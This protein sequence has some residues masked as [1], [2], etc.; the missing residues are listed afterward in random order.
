MKHYGG[1]TLNID[2]KKMDQAWVNRDKDPRAM[3]ELIGYFQE[4]AE[5]FARKFGINYYYRDDYISESLDQAQRALTNFN[6]NKSTTYSYFYK[7]MS[8][9]FRYSLRRDGRKRDKMPNMCSYDELANMAS[10][11]AYD[12]G[13]H[14]ADPESLEE[15]DTN[16]VM[17]QGK[18]FDKEDLIALVKEGK[19][20]A[21]KVNKMSSSEAKE[22]FINKIESKLLKEC[23]LGII[24]KK[25]ARDA[26]KE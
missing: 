14:L 19:S 10:G 12:D 5:Y 17:F 2:K 20:L 23:V 25:E 26:K 11:K 21:R 1:Y 18:Q 15:D 8:N 16:Q 4:M 6:L 13:Y 22:H 7:V 24:S 3:Y 9:S